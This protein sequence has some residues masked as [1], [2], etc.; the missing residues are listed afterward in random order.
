MVK[1]SL[2]V[3]VG[4]G[5]FLLADGSWQNFAQSS[6][7]GACEGVAESAKLGLGGFGAAMLGALW[8]YNGWNVI[9]SVGGE[10][11]DP[12]RTLPRALVGG[13][14]LVIALYLLV[15]AFLLVNTLVTTPWRALA[16]LGLIAVGLPIY[17][18]FARRLGSVVPTWLGGDGRGA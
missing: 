8:G 12:G 15:T 3:G 9:A 7:L 2:V 16:G 18:Y 4:A 11:E 1:V 13:T 6:A 17:S 5:A 14:L 10:V